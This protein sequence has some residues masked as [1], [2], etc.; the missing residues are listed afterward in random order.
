[1]GAGIAQVSIDKGMR[2]IMKDMSM[3]GLARGINQVQSGIDLKVKKKKILQLDGERFMSNLEATI[4]YDRFKD[5]DMIIEAVFEDINV[6]HK[7]IKE[8]GLMLSFALR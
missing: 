2:T 1:M 7:V 5:V 8:V 6:K 4:N 3:E